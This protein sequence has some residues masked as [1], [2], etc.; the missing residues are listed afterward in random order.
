VFELDFVD[1]FELEL[2][3]VFEAQVEWG[4]TG[5]F[6]WGVIGLNHRVE[7]VQTSM[8]STYVTLEEFPRNF[9]V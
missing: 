3:D 2:V 7:M 9:R 6:Y 8:K 4:G 1:I 5:R